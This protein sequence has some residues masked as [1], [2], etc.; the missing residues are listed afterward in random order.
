[1]KK[2]VLFAVLSLAAFAG[3]IAMPWRDQCKDTLKGCQP[4]KGCSPNCE[5]APYDDGGGSL[6]WPPMP[7]PHSDSFE[8]G[9][10]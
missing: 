10:L 7:P 2:L 1:M 3:S 9:K 5:P 6:P 8:K 4:P